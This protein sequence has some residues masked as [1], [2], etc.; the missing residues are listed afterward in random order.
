MKKYL[1]IASLFILMLASVN[2]LTTFQDEPYSQ[3]FT[4][5]EEFGQTRADILTSSNILSCSD[6]SNWQAKSC[7]QLYF[8]YAILPEGSTSIYDASVKECVDITDISP[9]LEVK[10][11]QSPKGVLNYVTTFLVKVD[12][13]CDLS[14][15][16][17]DEW[18]YTPSLLAVNAHDIR[19]VCAQGEMLWLNP[20]AYQYE[21]HLAKR[22]CLDTADTGLCANVWDLFAIDT[23]NDGVVS[24]IEKT[25]A[26][27][28][29][30]DR[31][32]DKN[33]D[34]IYEYPHGDGVCDHGFEIVDACKQYARAENGQ[35][36]CTIPGTNGI[37][38]TFDKAALFSCDDDVSSP[39]SKICDDI[40]TDLCPTT[41]VPVCV[42]GDG[43]QTWPNACLAKANGYN[44]FVPGPCADGILQCIGSD[45]SSCPE[46]NVCVGGSI[47]GITTTCLAGMCEYSG[48]CGNLACNTDTD[49]EAIDTNACVGITA[50]CMGGYCGIAGACL[51]PPVGGTFSFWDMIQ[52]LWSQF[53]ISV[54]DILNVN[55]AT[56]VVLCSQ[57]PSIWGTDWTIE[58]Y[59]SLEPNRVIYARS[60]DGVSCTYVTDCKDPDTGTTISTTAEMTSVI[61]CEN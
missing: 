4:I 5:A 43:G 52:Q 25:S 56:D 23:N 11:F 46:L 8:C 48:L 22:I 18:S 51:E 33:G 15:C 14:S 55:A 47:S 30:E 6:E 17:A 35:I 36:V 44:E 13:T 12:I 59:D 42:G 21:C 58:E 39:H 60:L 32:V 61:S 7:D 41:F 38:D 45:T 31:P 27:S 28:I 49:C 50:S 29:C 40:D 24:D 53:W 34:G 26:S 57:S 10:N 1:L 54:A 9:T 16:K 19:T 2:A 3:V 37:D 20:V